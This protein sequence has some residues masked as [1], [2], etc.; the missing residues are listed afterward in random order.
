MAGDKEKEVPEVE[1]KVT[2]SGAV[3]GSGAE[4]AGKHGDEE[5]TGAQIAPIVKLE[6]VAIST[7]EENEEVLI[8]M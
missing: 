6:E 3:E 8:D 5:D 2:P 4:E 1:E 7:G